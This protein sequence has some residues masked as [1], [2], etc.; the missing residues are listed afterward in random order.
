M[1][2]GVRPRPQFS[3]LIF[4]SSGALHPVYILCD[5]FIKSNFPVLTTG[6]GNDPV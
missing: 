3:F 4:S 6:E 2:V 1:I 5:I